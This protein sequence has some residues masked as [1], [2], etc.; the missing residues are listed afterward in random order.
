MT[1]TY[2]PVPSAEDLS[3]DHNAIVHIALQAKNNGQKDSTQWGWA[4]KVGAAARAVL[5]KKGR[6]KPPRVESSNPACA[7]NR[8]C[9]VHEKRKKNIHTF[10]S[11]GPRPAV[12]IDA[13]SPRKGPTGRYG[14]EDEGQDTVAAGKNCGGRVQS[15]RRRRRFMETGRG[16]TRRVTVR[17]SALSFLPLERGGS[18]KVPEKGATSRQDVEEEEEEDEK[19]VQQRQGQDIGIRYSLYYS[20]PNFC[21]SAAGVLGEL[22]RR[23]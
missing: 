17:A 11:T 19:C 15:E 9:D 16:R 21:A 12:S 4:H 22:R 1:S 2:V 8:T 3:M 5:T 6:V 20:I 14:R 18:W 23:T 10:A 13:P 7:T